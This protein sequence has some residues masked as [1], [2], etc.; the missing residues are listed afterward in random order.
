MFFSLNSESRLTANGAENLEQ[1]FPAKWQNTATLLPP[2][3]R[4]RASTGRRQPH[5]PS[6]RRAKEH[7]SPPVRSERRRT[8]ILRWRILFLL[9]LLT[10]AN[11]TSQ[12]SKDVRLVSANWAEAELTRS[13]SQ[14]HFCEYTP[15]CF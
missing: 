13:L 5:L 3:R 8:A 10:A 4:D 7:G 15:I 2:S 1:I 11:G 9:H 6:C 12:T 14:S